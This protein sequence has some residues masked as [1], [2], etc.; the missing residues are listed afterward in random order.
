[1]EHGSSLFS[2][3]M[4]ML[5]AAIADL[6]GHLANW[7]LLGAGLVLLDLR[8]GIKA[9]RRRGETIRT[10]R[11]WRRTINK[12]VDYLGWV[13]VAEMMSR[14]FGVSLGEPVVSL[15]ALFIVFGIE[16]SSCANNYFEYKG[17]PWRI[18]IWKLLRRKSELIGAAMS[19]SREAGTPED[20]DKDN[21]D[22]NDIK[23]KRG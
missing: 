3:F 9:A 10:S 6:Y 11:A 20:R 1:M 16:I 8:F 5:G 7:L 2:A 13:A 21:R 15:G 23:E 12:V 4:V 17:L 19:D 14:T 22:I 18:D